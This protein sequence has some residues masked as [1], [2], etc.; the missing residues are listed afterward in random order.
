MLQIACGAAKN[1][2]PDLNKII[3]IAIDAPKLAKKNSEDFV[4]LDCESWSAEQ[5]TFYEEENKALRF[6]ATDSM[7]VEKK[8]V[9][10]F[11]P[12]ASTAA[13]G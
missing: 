3:G 7:R 1:T 4:L 6:F 11:P 5:A 9:S 12:A 8:T 10:N 13:A 2:F